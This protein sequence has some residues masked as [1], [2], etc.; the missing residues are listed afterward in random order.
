MYFEDGMLL[1]EIGEKFG[2][3]ESRVSQILIKALIKLRRV[4]KNPFAGKRK[5]ENMENQ[6][7]VVEVGAGDSKTEVKLEVVR[8]EPAPEPALVNASV[9]SRHFGRTSTHVYSTIK[10][11]K[12]QPVKI[13][14]RKEGGNLYYLSQFEAHFSKPKA[15][16]KTSQGEQLGASGE[17]SRAGK[18]RKGR[19]NKRKHHHKVSFKPQFNLAPIL[20]A[21][22]AGAAL[23]YFFSHAH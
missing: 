20:L 4:T 18:L 17:A 16:R 2:V 1:R 10:K 9:I 14:G 22:A 6:E 23:I 21:A 7:H 11:H 3:C 15:P 5:V 8:G 12:I 19:K 13:R